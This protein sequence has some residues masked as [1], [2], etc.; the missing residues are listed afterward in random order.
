MSIRQGVIYFFIGSVGSG[1]SYHATAQIINRMS[2][3]GH[4]YTN[5]PLSNEFM[6]KRG[7]AGR[8]NLLSDDDM[9]QVLAGSYVLPDGVQGCRN[10]LVLDEISSYMNARD[11]KRDDEKTREF[12][13]WSKTVRHHRCQL[14]FI[15]QHF[16]NI[17]AQI[18]RLS[19]HVV[20]HLS[21]DQWQVMGL[22]LCPWPVTVAKLYREKPAANKKPMA[23]N[24][25]MRGEFYKAYN[26]F[27]H[28]DVE[29]ALTHGA[30]KRGG[31]I[32]T[33]FVIAYALINAAIIIVGMR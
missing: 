2:E 23:T 5:I 6:Q 24:F 32:P 27:A 29:S 25:I 9:E 20:E 33:W 22:H 31:I 26:S 10:L 1:K 28:E 16:E 14:I 11:W 4:V 18:R 8:Y 7:L 3:G 19:Q 30:I 17:S 15:E 12:F 13:K 21:L